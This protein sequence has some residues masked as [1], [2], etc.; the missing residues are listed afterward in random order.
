[1]NQSVW[2]NVIRV[3]NVAQVSLHP[4]KKL[5]TEFLPETPNLHKGLGLWLDSGSCSFKLISTHLTG[6]LQSQAMTKERA[7][8]SLLLLRFLP[9]HGKHETCRGPSGTNG[10][11]SEPLP[12][13]QP[14]NLLLF[15]GPA[16][17]QQLR[18]A[19][20]ESGLWI[21]P[22]KKNKIWKPKKTWRSGKWCSYPFQS[23]LTFWFQTPHP[24]SSHRTF[25]DQETPTLGADNANMRTGLR[26][27]V[28][29]GHEVAVKSCH[30]ARSGKTSWLGSSG[31]ASLMLTSNNSRA[32]SANEAI[33]SQGCRD[34]RISHNKCNLK[35][36][37][38]H[39]L[40]ENGEWMGEIKQ[41]LHGD[42]ETTSKQSMHTW[43]K[44]M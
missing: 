4:T 1:M 14:F 24:C 33:W 28:A 9:L 35:L 20:W 38:Q 21:T 10:T 16:P 43:A 30:G 36:S 17:A 44:V 34:I 26:G 39:V 11:P 42:L 32:L 37:I 6:L 25:S 19:G 31:W 2:W 5:L 8:K 29:S 3:L 22:P 41:S 18:K 40:Y 13:G 12:S 7:N 23:E 15:I 27:V